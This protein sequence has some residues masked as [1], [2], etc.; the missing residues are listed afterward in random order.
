[1]LVEVAVGAIIG[2]AIGYEIPVPV[3][4]IETGAHPTNTTIKNPKIRS[5]RVMAF[6]VL[7]YCF[8]CNFQCFI[9][10][11]KAVF[12]LFLS[13]DQRRDDQDRVPM[14]V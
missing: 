2:V 11:T 4:V 6:A 7:L 5:R 1:M 12:Q 13:N 9:K 8:V 3:G 14:C 10:H